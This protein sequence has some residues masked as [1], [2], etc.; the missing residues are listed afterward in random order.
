M[1]EDIKREETRQPVSDE[2]LEEAAGGFGIT[3]L[4]YDPTKKSAAER[5]PYQPGKKPEVTLL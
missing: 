2:E 1:S 4:P 3:L 5:L